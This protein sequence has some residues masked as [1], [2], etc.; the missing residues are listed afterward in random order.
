[1]IPVRN[2]L[3]ESKVV[4]GRIIFVFALVAVLALILVV[5]LGYLQI[6]QHQRFTTLAQ[7]NRID[8]FALPPVRG[9]VYDRNGEVLAQN[10]RVFNL[11]VLPDKVDD[12]EALL[13]E[14]GQFIELTDTHLEQFRTLLKRRPSFERQTL[15]ANLNEEEAA[16]LAVNQHR[17]P[18]AELRARLQRYYPR[19]ELTAHVIGYVG[20]ISTHDLE[21]IDNQV[22]RGMEYIGKSGIEA[23]Y[24]STLLGQSGVERVETNAHGRIVRTLE[25]SAPDTG[26]TIHLSLD[27]KLQQKAVEA[28]KGY[29]GAV[30]AIEPESGDVLAFASVPSYDPNP[31]VNGISKT[32]YEKL[33]SSIRRPLVNRALHGRYAPGSTIKGFMALV[34]MENGIPHSTTSYCP[35][36]FS[37][38]GR[39]HRYRCWKKPGHGLMDGH[40]AI[41]QSCDVYFYRMAKQ[42]G[43]DR[44][45]DGMVRFGFGEES[46]IDMLGEPSGL[47]PSREWKQRARNQVWYPGETIITG[48]GQGYMLVTPLQLAAATATLANRGK[49]FTPRFLTAIEHPQSQVQDIIDPELAGVESLADS[50]FYD[51]VIKSMQDVVHGARGTARRLSQGIEYEMAGKTGTAQVKSIAQ[52]QEYDEKT[53]ENKCKDPSLFIGFAP[54]DDPKI[55]IA[56]VVEHAGSGSRVA[57]PIARK[58]IDYYLI[59]RLGLFNGQDSTT[60]N[61]V[62]Q[63]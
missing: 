36:W 32:A 16:I 53:T 49:K 57:A 56:V 1:M 52:N 41:V 4:H 5:R 19:G 44:M 45:H 58:L 43:I 26:E 11:E 46:G 33:R 38:P 13:A 17:Y 21:N 28:L 2:Y 40:D 35:G 51:L 27:I 31:F 59:N 15:K 12:M 18:G 3:L 22:Y 50:R 8:F 25:Q 39:K 61:L 42:L 24:E 47:M 10:F 14:L 23:F 54:L 7:N 34:G 48:I 20:R 29:E 30:V 9:I 37:L 62:S 60:Q 55:A 63:G 6:Y